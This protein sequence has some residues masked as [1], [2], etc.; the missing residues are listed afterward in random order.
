M[1]GSLWGCCRRSLGS[2]CLL[3]LGWGLQQPWSLL[4]GCGGEEKGGRKG[5][6]GQKGDR[7]RVSLTLGTGAAA[8]PRRRGD[9][10]LRVILPSSPKTRCRE[11]S[12]QRLGI[13][14]CPEGV[15][16]GPLWL[17]GGCPGGRGSR[18]AEVPLRP[19][20]PGHWVAPLVHLPL[21]TWM[22]RSGHP[23]PPSPLAEAEWLCSDFAFLPLSA[24]Q[25]H[26]HGVGPLSSSVKEPPPFGSPA[27]TSVTASAGSPIQFPPCVHP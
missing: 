19:C 9:A 4:P 15:Q 6:P 25:T 2:S 13:L 20:A 24:S 27:P 18:L 12:A 8:T 3:G 1:T 5:T 7:G 16:P 21:C 26:K 10:L 17:T 14:S 11:G 22:G 23:V